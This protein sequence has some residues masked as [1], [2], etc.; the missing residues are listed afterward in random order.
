VGEPEPVAPVPLVVKI[1]GGLL[2]AGGLDGLHRAC[3][4][5]TELA[6]RRPALVVPGGGPFADAVRA[7]DAELSLADDVAHALALRAMDQLGVL[8]A[9]LLPGAERL[10]GLT[11]PRGLGIVEAATAFAGLPDVPES[12]AVTSDSLAV[13][14]AA[15][16]GAREAILLKPVVGVLARWPPDDADGCAPIPALTAAELA[17]AQARG[18]GRAVDAYLSEAVRRTGVAVIVRSPGAGAGTRIVPV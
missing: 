5:V 7:V 14:A 10:A 6:A 15:A 16:I 17:E 8:L 1:G 2:R 4:E 11:V 9:R 13:F 12:W 18:G 3:A